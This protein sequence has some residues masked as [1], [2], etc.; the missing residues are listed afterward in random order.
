MLPLHIVAVAMVSATWMASTF[1]IP[2]LAKKRFE[3]ADWKVLLVAMAPTSLFVLSIFWNDLFGRRTLGKYLGVYWLLASAPLGL[4]GL[5]QGYWGLLIPYLLACIG[6]AGY[7]PVAGEL[8]KGLYPDKVRGRVYSVV[9]GGSTVIGA[10]VGFGMG[11]WLAADGDAFRMIFPMLAVVQGI[12]VGLM[13]FLWRAT[14]HAVG[15]APY[16]GVPWSL[17]KA[18][19]PIVHMRSV[20]KDDPVFLRY[21]GAYMTYGVG[22][23]ICWAL[24]PILVTT[25]LGL[26]YDQI[27]KSTQVAYLLAMVAAIVP[28]G[29]LM[30][31]IGPVRSTAVSFAFLAVHPIGLMMVSNDRELLLV[32]LAYGAAHA[33]ANLGWMLGPV[34]LAP[35]K[36][37]V[38]QYVAIHATLVGVRGTIFQGV[39]VGL[40]WATGSFLWPL[41]LAAAAYV[42]SAVQMWRLNGFMGAR[43]KGP[44]PTPDP[45]IADPEV[46]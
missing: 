9:W 10:G 43:L 7:H 12:G 29:M 38:A 3:A 27:A 45:V 44:G 8:L 4:I 33:G 37:K 36:E 1:L 18:L 14:G 13:Y 24:V 25:K 11:E 40:Y 19:D 32:S 42:W 39:G 16:A 23:M 5:A 2:V 15:R 21:E 30:D 26:Q 34:A 41:V 31:R 46:E 17:R 6:S 35:S 28:A 20:L 22:W